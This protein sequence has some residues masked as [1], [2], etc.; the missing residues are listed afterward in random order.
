MTAWN[1]LSEREKELDR[2]IGQIAGLN[3]KKTKCCFDMLDTTIESVMREIGAF[4]LERDFVIDR[5]MKN[6]V[7][8]NAIYKPDGLIGECETMLEKFEVEDKK[9]EQKGKELGFGFDEKSKSLN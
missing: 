3:F 4:P 8:G 6:V 5:M 9:W 1:N 7:V 2:Q